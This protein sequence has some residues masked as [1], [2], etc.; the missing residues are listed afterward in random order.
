MRS[1]DSSK[2]GIL[3]LT[4]LR[5]ALRGAGARRGR[6]VGDFV[7]GW[8]EFLLTL[9]GPGREQVG[10][11]GFQGGDEP[12]PVRD[13]W[14]EL[15]EGDAEQAVLGGAVDEPGFV[16]SVKVARHS[17]DLRRPDRRATTAHETGTREEW[18]A[19]QLELLEA[20]KARGRQ[21]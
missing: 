5:S 2:R 21:C 18:L 16:C 6:G 19:T 8:D 14:G 17:L 9:G 20:E 3:K 4:S 12:L 13:L 7:E 10:E 11:L 15:D 1:T